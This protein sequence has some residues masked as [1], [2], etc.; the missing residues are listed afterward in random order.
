METIFLYSIGTIFGV[1]LIYI[2][3][4]S[5]AP[6]LPDSVKNDHFECGLP[7]SS[8]MPQK[9]NFNYF[10]FAIMFIVIDMAGLFFSIFIFTENRETLINLAIFSLILFVALSFAMKEYNRINTKNSKKRER[11]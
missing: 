3:G 5:I 1:F 10:S 11:I 6:Y 4:I 8:E 9:A 7:P 2:L